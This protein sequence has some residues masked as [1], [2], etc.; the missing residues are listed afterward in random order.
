MPQPSKFDR[1][2]LIAGYVTAAVASTSFV[3]ISSGGSAGADHNRQ[4]SPIAS[5]SAEELTFEIDAINNLLFSPSRITVPANTPLRIRL[6][7]RTIIYHDLVIPKFNARLDRIGP[8]ESG[9]LLVRFEPGEYHFY[10][11]IQSHHQAGM[12]GTIEAV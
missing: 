1:R 11:S 5:P 6:T 2:A 10:C 4:A 8:D 3:F 12:E 7:N 9:D